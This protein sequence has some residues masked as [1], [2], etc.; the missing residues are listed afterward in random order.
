MIFESWVWKEN[1]KREL[2]E[3]KSF[4]ATGVPDDDQAYAIFNFKIEHFFFTSSF[5][6]RKLMEAHK[7]S[8]ELLS[9][10]YP[11]S[12]YLRSN[13]D[14]SIDRWNK[15]RIEDFYDTENPQQASIN[16]PNFC[17]YFIHSFIFINLKSDQKCQGVLVNSTKIKDQYLYYVLQDTCFTLIT[18]VIEDQ[19]NMISAYRP[20]NKIYTSKYASKKGWESIRKQAGWEDKRKNDE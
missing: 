5:I 10:N 9:Q 13:T 8:G 18:D 17:N 6:I 20:L 14:T 16:I 7:L 4:I 2:S 3:F 12:R 11:S 1:L 19:V 15:H